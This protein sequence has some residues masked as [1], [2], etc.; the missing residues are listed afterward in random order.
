M[1]S[2][3]ATV[4]KR[5]RLLRPVVLAV[6]L[7]SV[8]L[9]PG[10]VRGDAAPVKIAV[11]N[12]ELEDDSPAAMLLNKGARY[13]V[14]MEQVTNEA[15]QA[16][17]ASGRY[18]IVDVH[19]SQAKPVLDKSLRNCEGCE[20]QLALQLGAQQSMIGIV[21]TVTQTDYY[22]YVCIRDARTGK[23]LD[24]E[25]A[26]FAGDPSGWPTGV[27]MLIKHQVLPSQG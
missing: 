19:A 9:S 2:G 15:R 11:F 3:T 25:E 20:A 27:R 21:R 26:N 5:V 23:I 8:I 7:L 17:V 16:L 14:T 10:L 24:Q 1:T 6:L 22:V 13:G 12:F 4:L 18:S